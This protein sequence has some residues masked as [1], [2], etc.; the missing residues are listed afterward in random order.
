MCPCTQPKRQNCLIR[1]R[2]VFVLTVEFLR[3]QGSLGRGTGSSRGGEAFWQHS[4][5]LYPLLGVLKN[6]KQS[7]GADHSESVSTG[8]W[9]VPGSG[10]GL[11][12]PSNPQNCRKKKTQEK[13]T[14]IFCAK[15]WYSPNPGSEEIWII[16]MLLYRLTVII[17]SICSTVFHL[18]IL[19]QRR[20]QT[21][22]KTRSPTL[23][24]PSRP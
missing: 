16:C 7:F 8:V 11:K 9:C 10:A 17:A 22:S 13:G 15:L 19:P 3:G 12:S 21:T 1:N 23:W 5:C 14:F 4:L 18:L 2:S 20:A 6:F 24:L